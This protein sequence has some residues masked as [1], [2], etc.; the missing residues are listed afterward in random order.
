MTEQ[1]TYVNMG[2]LGDF[3][4]KHK[5]EVEE[6]SVD[7]YTKL[8][9]T[10][11]S[12]N[13]LRD[14][15]ETD[16]PVFDVILTENRVLAARFKPFDNEFIVATLSEHYRGYSVL[17][18]EIGSIV[19][20]MA[21]EEF[22][23]FHDFE[24]FLFA[25]ESISSPFVSPDREPGQFYRK[26]SDAFV[27]YW[28]NSPHEELIPIS[29][30]LGPDTE[31][32]INNKETYEITYGEGKFQISK[33]G[34]LFTATRDTEDIGQITA[35]FPDSITPEQIQ[36]LEQIIAT[37]IDWIELPRLLPIPQYSRSI[38]FDKLQRNHD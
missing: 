8:T 19:D 29:F 2:M 3:I 16:N 38:P 20:I 36:E 18:Y 32:T 28:R 7:K 21:R 31:L 5:L 17:L 14:R 33:D 35:K 10:N 26:I 25:I 37:G 11:P 30:L 24:S 15:Y 1:P 12:N 34:D 4:D 27:C 23:D 13:Y 6:T 9:L 22:N